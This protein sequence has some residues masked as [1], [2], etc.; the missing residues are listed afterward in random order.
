[1]R[2]DWKRADFLA[3]LATADSYVS[4]HRSEGFGMGMAEAMS[5]GKVVI[6]TDFSG[7]TEFLDK[8]TGY[9]VP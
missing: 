7:N 8:E 9:V 1:M 5:S 3:L 4:L 6:A 2:G